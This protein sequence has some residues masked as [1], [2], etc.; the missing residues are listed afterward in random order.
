VQPHCGIRLNATRPPRQIGLDTR[1]AQPP[2]WAGNVGGIGATVGTTGYSG[3]WG[4]VAAVAASTGQIQWRTS[5]GRNNYVADIE[6]GPEVVTAAVGHEVGS[7]PGEVSP[8][9]FRVLGL[10]PRTGKHL[11]SKRVGSDGQSRV[12]A[13]DGSHVVIATRQHGVLGVDARTGKPDWRS[14]TPA[15]CGAV[16]GFDAGLPPQPA[17]LTGGLVAIGWRCRHGGPDVVAVDGSTG[18]PR[19][20]WRAPSSTGLYLQ[21]HLYFAHGAVA[22]GMHGKAARTLPTVPARKRFAWP[23]SSGRPMTVVVLSRSGKPR[24]S[25][26]NVGP[27]WAAYDDGRRMCV[28]G[29]PGIECRGEHSG[30]LLWRWHPK[31]R[32]SAG[33][34]LFYADSPVTGVVVADDKVYWAAPTRRCPRR[35]APPKNDHSF[36]RGEFRLRV[37]DL[38][39]GHVLS[40]HLLPAY[41]GGTDGVGTSAGEPSAVL[42]VAGGFALVDPQD[43]GSDVTEAMRVP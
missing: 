9:I 25:L 32:S 28:A 35:A 6:A 12:A 16:G 43:G 26:A 38:N 39:D 19:W 14:E 41:N 31:V 7:P 10:D 37:M 36:R 30:R 42:A 29:P 1:N 21:T 3:G 4:C 15:T 13:V 17:T 23:S 24:W 34:S 11:W 33:T 5:T 40:N 8:H 20:H 22:I 2:A 18:H 27:G